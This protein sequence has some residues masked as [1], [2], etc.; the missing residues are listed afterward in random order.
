M[1][2]YKNNYNVFLNGNRIC[3]KCSSMMSRFHG[4][5]DIIFKCTECK[6]RYIIADQNE[7]IEK[8]M[9]LQEVGA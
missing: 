7:I 3:P 6:T 1:S 5:E 9:T 2:N 4:I 8:E